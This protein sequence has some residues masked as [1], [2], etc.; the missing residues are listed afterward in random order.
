MGAYWVTL[1]VSP[2]FRDWHFEAIK[3]GGES[4]GEVATCAEAHL[5]YQRDLKAKG[6]IIAGG[7]TVAFTSALMLISAD[8]LEE[9]K[10]LAENDPGVKGGLLTDPKIEPWYHMN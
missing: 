10:A 8:S 5:R 3:Q 7:P 2:A 4:H 6:K 9:A 1:T